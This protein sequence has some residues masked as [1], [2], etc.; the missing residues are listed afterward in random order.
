LK[1]ALEVV[2]CE[3]DVVISK[4]QSCIQSQCWK[5]S[6]KLE[7]VKKDMEQIVNSLLI[8]CENDLGLWNY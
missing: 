1:G 2:S 6:W 4:K 3:I 7:G 5:W 8:A